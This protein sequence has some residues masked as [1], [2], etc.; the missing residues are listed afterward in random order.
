M[1][2]VTCV[3]T[4]EGWCAVL[5]NPPMR[6]VKGWDAVPTLCGFEIFGSLSFKKGTP[7][8][9]KCLDILEKKYED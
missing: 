4:R 1:K 2:A 9:E 8:C 5:G 6:D 3:L 7:D